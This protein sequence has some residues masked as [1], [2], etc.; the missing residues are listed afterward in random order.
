MWLIPSTWVLRG[1]ATLDVIQR[2]FEKAGVQFNADSLGVRL[3]PNER[4]QREAPKI[5][6]TLE[7]LR[8]RFNDNKKPKAT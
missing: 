5:E 7:L 2:A 4:N 1:S 6:Q 8:S 3:K